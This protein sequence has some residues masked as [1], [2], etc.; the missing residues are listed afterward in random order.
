MFE[1]DSLVVNESGRV[2]ELTKVEDEAMGKSFSISHS[3]S[4]DSMKI[5][6]HAR[7][8]AEKDEWVQAL[9]K[10][11]ISFNQHK[12]LSA[13]KEKERRESCSSLDETK[14]SPQV[15]LNGNEYDNDSGHKSYDTH[16]D[17]IP[18]QEEEHSKNDTSD[19][20]VVD[21]PP[22]RLKRS[23]MSLGRSRSPNKR[24]EKKNSV[25]F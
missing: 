1:L 9:S 6:L 21:A 13:S 18:E 11:M 3:H 22:S 12:S 2:E 8:P 16:V 4:H 17:D 5:E 19:V 14:S 23:S 25:L 24:I 7:T 20:V 15:M 10:A